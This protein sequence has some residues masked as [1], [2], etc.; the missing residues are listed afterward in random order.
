MTKEQFRA[1]AEAY[2]GEISRWPEALR[3]DAL[4]L[5]SAQPEFAQDV[6]ARE[7]QL[8]EALDALPRPVV[9]RALHDRVVAGAPAPRRRRRWLDWLIPV[10]AG[11][12]LA[13]AAAAG[14]VMGVQLGSSSAVNAEASAQAVADLDVSG[15]A[16]EG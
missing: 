2:G 14:L 16:E 12:A 15:V 1:L 9:S 6:L 13:G 7:R 11:A 8:D 10:G 3:E 4:L 5:A